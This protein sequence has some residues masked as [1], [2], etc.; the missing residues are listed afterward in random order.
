MAM[1]LSLEEALPYYYLNIIT[2]NSKLPLT[3]RFWGIR[4]EIH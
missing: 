1:S 2:A 4:S 3:A